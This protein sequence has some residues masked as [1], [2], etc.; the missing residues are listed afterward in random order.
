MGFGVFVVF[1]LVF[2]F[3]S[4]FDLKLI[5][6]VFVWKVKEFEK[7]NGWFNMFKNWGGEDDDMSYRLV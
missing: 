7:I 2:F 6:G 4:L 1:L 5:G 3:Y